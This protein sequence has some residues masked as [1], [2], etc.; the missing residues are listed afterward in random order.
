LA[1]TLQPSDAV[2]FHCHLQFVQVGYL[3]LLV[4]QHGGLRTDLRHR[5]ELD[6]SRRELA[7]QVHEVNELPGVDYL[8]N[9]LGYRIPYPRHFVQLSLFIHILDTLSHLCYGMGG[10]P[11]SPGLERL[12]SFQFQEVRY[13]VEYGGDLFIEHLI[14]MMIPNLR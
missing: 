14:A 5:H 13:L 1:E 2:L 8:G 6:Q 11:V 7:P 3:E 12:T 9:L 4:K 10:V